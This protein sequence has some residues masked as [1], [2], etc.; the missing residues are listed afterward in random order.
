MDSA[1]NFFNI[2]YLDVPR[3]Y[4]KNT[5]TPILRTYYLE[6]AYLQNRTL[7]ENED[8]LSRPCRIHMYLGLL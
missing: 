5:R 3:I 6:H 2:S 4:I 1:H 7:Y 8:A